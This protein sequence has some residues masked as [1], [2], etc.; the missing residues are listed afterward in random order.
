[1]DPLGLD[2]R[3]PSKT[4]REEYLS[5]SILLDPQMTPWIASLTILQ[6]SLISATFGASIGQICAFL[7]LPEAEILYP[8]S[9]ARAA[10]F[11]AWMK[12]QEYRPFLLN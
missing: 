7:E 10:A 5:W 6:G 3:D 11:A 12:L 4:F 1:M 8:V 9:A 2:L